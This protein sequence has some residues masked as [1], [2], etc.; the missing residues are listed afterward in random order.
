LGSDS[1]SAGTLRA[2]SAADSRRAGAGSARRRGFLLAVLGCVATQPLVAQPSPAAPVPAQGTITYFIA[3]GDPA[4]AYRDGDP[5]LARWALGAWQR[6]AVGAFELAEVED[7]DDAAIRIVFAGARGG[8]FGVMSPSRSATG[9]MRATVVIYPDTAAFGAEI[10][11]R[12]QSDPLY[13]DTIV[14]LTC[15]HEIGHA[16]GLEHTAEFA[17]IMYWFGFGG[18]IP[19]FFGRYRERLRTRADIA[20]FSG[21][22]PGDV[23]QLRATER[24]ID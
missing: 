14:Y 11:E 22:S 3:A 23:A 8:T 12:A 18:D 17:D 7:P 24:E 4:A 16:L 13:R 10:A 20:R 5:E 1:I 2:A 6:A 21:L 19:G 9:T 15:V